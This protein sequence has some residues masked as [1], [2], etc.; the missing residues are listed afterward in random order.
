[1]ARRDVIG[2]LVHVRYGKWTHLVLSWSRAS[3]SRSRNVITAFIALPSHSRKITI[4]YF[5][6][7]QVDDFIS[8][9]RHISGLHI[10]SFSRLGRA[11]LA[12]ILRQK[13]RLLS[14]PI[15]RFF[16]PSLSD[17][18][19]D[20][21]IDADFIFSDRLLPFHHF[22]T[23]YGVEIGHTGLSVPFMPLYFRRNIGSSLS[24]SSSWLLFSTYYLGFWHIEIDW[25][26]FISFFS[27]KVVSWNA[28]KM[29]PFLAYIN[30]F[31][32]TGAR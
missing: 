24:V 10:C 28:F 17:D 22:I 20:I 13:P 12:K 32:L 21:F 26:F 2:V 14:S 30:E 31:C 19:G 11:L 29:T 7:Y 15:P 3:I 23:R 27:S 1:M 5:S 16:M 9:F 18:C 6:G 25:Y 8:V 4:S